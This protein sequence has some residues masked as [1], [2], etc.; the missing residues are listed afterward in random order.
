[1]VVVVATAGEDGKLQD[2][3]VQP[4]EVYQSMQNQLNKQKTHDPLALLRASHRAR[5]SKGGGSGGGDDDLVLLP[6]PQR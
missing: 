5:A 3:R 6:I 1:M 4:E 2:G